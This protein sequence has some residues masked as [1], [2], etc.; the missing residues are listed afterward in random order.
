MAG[1]LLNGRHGDL[2]LNKAHQGFGILSHLFGR[3]SA[4]GLLKFSDMAW[5]AY[6]NGCG[7]VCVEGGTVYSPFTQYL[8]IHSLDSFIYMP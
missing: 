4:S 3:I 2:I 6:L 1:K 5:C 8:E 7:I